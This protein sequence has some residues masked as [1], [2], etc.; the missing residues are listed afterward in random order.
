MLEY[1]LQV[2]ST[3]H[4]AFPVHF[5]YYSPDGKVTFN[6]LGAASADNY[7]VMFNLVFPGGHFGKAVTL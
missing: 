6:T 4:W 3:G 2:K 1:K 7:G 5:L